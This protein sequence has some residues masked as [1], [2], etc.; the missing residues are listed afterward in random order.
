[1]Q[2]VSSTGEHPCDNIEKKLEKENVPAPLMLKKGCQVRR[3][4]KACSFLPLA[5]LKRSCEKQNLV[6]EI[7]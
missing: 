6:K 5:L 7:N 4:K 2:Q 1:L 3:K